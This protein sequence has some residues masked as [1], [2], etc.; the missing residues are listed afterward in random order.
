M[1]LIAATVA[2]VGCQVLDG[3][4]DMPSE[5]ADL[6]GA[7]ATDC[8]TVASDDDPGGAW[9]CA[10]T[11]FN[12]GSAFFIVYDAH[13]SDSNI[14]DSVVSDGTTVWM[15]RQDDYGR[16]KGPIDAWECTAPSVSAGDTE[17]Y[18]PTPDVDYVKCGGQAPAGN[19][20]LLC[21]REPGANPPPL[22]FPEAP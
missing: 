7:G 10:I 20:Y 5:A 22:P 6:A 9:D 1:K 8:G 14:T 18:G 21:G 17:D 2:L 4:C 19:N 12:A 3:P 11:A 15:L 16:G 13:G